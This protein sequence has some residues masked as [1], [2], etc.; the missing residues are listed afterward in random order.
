MATFTWTPEFGAQ[1]SRK[2]RVKSIRFGDGY[3]QRVADGL[4]T[5]PEFWSLQ[6][7]NRTKAEADAIE[8]FLVEQN[9]VLSFDWT[10]PDASTSLKFICRDWTRTIQKANLYTIVAVFEQVYDI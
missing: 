3:E 8:A 2:P 9:A 5:N 6:F 4:N 1:K 7:A 10:P